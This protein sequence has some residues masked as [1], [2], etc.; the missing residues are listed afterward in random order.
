MADQLDKEHRY[1]EELVREMAE[2]GLL[3]VSVPEAYGGAGLDKLSY[4]I[5]MEE[6]SRGCASTGV[7]MSVNN[8]LVC[9]PI[10]RFGS[11][12]QKRKW[13]EPLARG[14]LLGCF[15][16][17][18]PGTGSDAAAQ[19]CMAVKDGDD[20]VINGTKNWITN[21]PHADMILVF[22]CTDRSHLHSDF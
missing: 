14:E 9:D 20:W 15:A 12:E 8:S 18:E 2:M 1:P 22:C 17:S 4:A 16:L 13:L 3:G 6:V 11:E 19:T 7:I 21:G 5:A 10:H